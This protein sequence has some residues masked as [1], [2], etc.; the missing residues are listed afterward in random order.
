MEINVEDFLP[1][2]PSDVDLVVSRKEF[3][4]LKLSKRET[5]EEEAAA[6]GQM[7]KVFDDDPIPTTTD[8]T[9]LF[10]YQ[11]YVSRFLSTFTPYD[12][13]LI[14]HEMGT[15]KTCTA[16]S[17]VEKMRY[18]P[19]TF[20]KGALVLAKG[21][22]LL[23]N[24]KNELIFTCTDGRYIP[25]NYEA[26]TV[27][28]RQHQKNKALKDFYSFKTFETF[29]KEIDRLS[30][31]AIRDLFEDHVI[32]VDE[33]HHVREYGGGDKKKRVIGK[34]GNVVIESDRDA[35][36]EAEGEAEGEEAEGEEGERVIKFD[37]YK[38]F[39]RFLHLL[40]RR[41]ILLLSGTP[42]KDGPEELA[43]V[44]NLILPLDR[45]LLTGNAFLDR[46]FDKDQIKRGDELSRKIAGRVSYLK[47]PKESDVVKVFHGTRLNFFK[48]YEDVMGDFQYAA[49]VAAFEADKAER[50]LFTKSRQASLFVFP[51]GSVGSAGF[52]RYVKET[53]PK[54]FTTSSEFDAAI[55]RRSGDFGYEFSAKYARTLKRI[56]ETKNKSFVYCQF[57][58]GSGCIVFARLLE[59]YLGYARAVD[60]DD[61]RTKADRFALITNKTSNDATT[62][63][64]I[65]RFNRPDNYAGDYIRIIIGSR[66]I[67]EGFTL[68]DVVDEHIL[69]PHWNYSETSQVISR[70]WRH[71]S[72]R[73]SKAKI[74]NIFQ[75][76]AA[77]PPRNRSNDVTSIDLDM[78]KLSESKD[79]KIKRLERVVKTSAFD[80]PLTYDRNAM[81]GYDGQRDCDYGP[82][83]YTCAGGSITY[84][85]NR[86]T[87]D[88][89]YSSTDRVDAYV[90][91]YLR[92]TGDALHVAGKSLRRLLENT[93][94]DEY[95][96][97]TSLSKFKTRVVIL[98]NR[99][100]IDG[101]LATLYDSTDFGRDVVFV[102]TT[103]IVGD[104][105]NG[106]SYY[107][108][109]LFVEDG[110]TFD[111]VNDKLFLGRI[112][113]VI[114]NLIDRPEYTKPILSLLDYAAQRDVLE[115]FVDLVHVR[116]TSPSNENSKKFVDNLFAAYRGFFDEIDGFWTIWLYADF[117]DNKA[118]RYDGEEW[119]D[120][121]V[122][123]RDKLRVPIRRSE[124]GHVGLVNPQ[125]DEFC[126]Q[127]VADD[128]EKTG[129][130]DKRKLN[131]GRR[132]A[133][134]DLYKLIDLVARKMK[135][136]VPDG[137]EGDD[138]NVDRR[139]AALKENKKRKL[140]GE[141]NVV[142]D[143]STKRRVIF[144]SSKTRNELC[145]TIRRW[146]EERD[147]L[148]QSM[149]CGTQIKRRR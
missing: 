73:Y 131:V 24:F 8:A 95:Q 51:D 71:G 81:T 99:L 41:K 39:F 68:K 6:I 77:L 83:E 76:V 54:R 98:K 94:A 103:P 145:A 30:D 101:V 134:W 115:T 146:F 66:V 106:Q 139:Y 120:V 60:A 108:E 87:Y 129:K 104:A 70:G 7:R 105:D 32:V 102:A 16:V 123:D 2:Y 47:A 116:G 56:A 69:S 114:Q 22:G 27:M 79:V 118:R 31:D 53:G 29:A 61:A 36:E 100:G 75:H 97:M 149:D 85:L 55:K 28:Q 135:I 132:C 49:Y 127:V 142:D 26:L 37:L 74:I 58:T 86:R 17:A 9:N 11:K 23:A 42:M 91:D 126:I 148:F 93:D 140:A 20:V 63:Q 38:S 107:A 12:E 44:M 18:E 84:P 33:I 3:A 57:V 137:G 14:Y 82:C 5:S 52:A 128:G 59:L 50:S 130:V 138:E 143:R 65:D 141:E 122:P 147:L 46:Y 78:Y 48:V 64:L 43:S 111:D 72:H 34:I 62:R 125:K 40:R 19:N 10:D 67:T 89:Y 21:K 124:V 25:K 119:I 90:E 136:A 144:W 13:L 96:L 88:A 1:S 113:N 109:N 15:G 35:D 80:C 45:Q 92:T 117:L 110:D 121:D 4:D 112:L 133:D